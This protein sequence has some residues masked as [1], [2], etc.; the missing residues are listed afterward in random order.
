MNATE[1]IS[2]EVYEKTGN[3]PEKYQLIREKA[4]CHQV[5]LW[6]DLILVPC[7]L[8]DRIMIYGQDLE[9]KGEI[10]F[11]RGTGPRHGVF[12]EDGRWL[13]LASE[14]SNEFFVIEAGT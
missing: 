10:V 2:G 14:L 9:K 8:L 5:L 11:E 4:G 3:V 12:T 13:Y 6:Q 7:L 1:H